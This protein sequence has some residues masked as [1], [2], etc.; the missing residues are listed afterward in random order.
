MLHAD[1]RFT[2]NSFLNCIVLQLN[3]ISLVQFKNYADAS[4]SF[5]QQVIGICG[6]NGIGK[7]N[8]LDAIHYLCF[9]K[10][11]F[12]R[13]DVQ[14]VFPGTGGFRIDGQFLKA[15]EQIRV[16]CILRENGRKE[17]S[18]NEEP[19]PKFAMH[20]G[21]LPCVIIAPDDIQIITAASEE[22]RR[23]LDVL[24]SQLDPVYL[25]NLITYMRVL[26]QRNSYLKQVSETKNFDQQLLLVYDEQL[27][28]TG[29]YIFQVRKAFLESFIP[30]VIAFYQ[31]ISGVEEPLLIEYESRLQTTEFKVLLDGSRDKDLLLQ[32][33][34]S[35]IHKDD[36]SIHLRNLPF[37]SIASQGQRKSLLFALKLA[38]FE[39][40]KQAKGFSPLL[41]LDDVFEKLD[42][43]RM[44]QLLR[45]VC[46][47]SD[48]QI[49]ITDT[50]EDRIKNHLDE[51][52]PD[53]Q[54]IVLGS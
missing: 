4:F 53:Y 46:R 26:Q 45:W 48:G 32:R 27:L 8:L 43:G 23:F 50:H 42:A 15:D 11:Y 18:V 2:K 34:N 33:T 44:H 19:Y 1:S 12:S 30:Q 24:L 41:L 35:G 7:T 16:V 21:Q 13:T 25:R 28:Q 36:L 5:D 38:E 22:R 10:S 3:S 37:K 39:V 40:L 54:M 52:T 49:F 47:E 20:I 29:E 6:P 17:F 9:T 31:K 14:N 51:L